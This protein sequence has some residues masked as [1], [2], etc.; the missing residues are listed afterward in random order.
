M[1][2][3]YAPH[4]APPTR[5]VL[6]RSAA[7]LGAGCA[8]SL[9]TQ[10]T[11]APAVSAAPVGARTMTIALGALPGDR[12]G[13]RT[14]RGLT[15]R[16]TK[17]YSLL[18]VSWDDPDARLTGTV[19][20]RTRCAGH[21]SDWQPLA[22]DTED[23]PDPAEAEGPHARGSTAPRWVGP[24]DGVEVRVTGNEP[25]PAGLRVD[26]VDPGTARLG[27]HPPTIPSDE[28][29]AS[30]PD[31]THRLARHEVAHRAPRPGIVTR[32]GWGADESLR[33]PGFTYT[34][35]VRVVFVHHTDTANDY[36]CDDSPKV[37]RAIYQYHV[38]TNGWNDI[39]YNFLVDRCGTIY[40]GR[41]GGVARPVLGAHTLG[42][43]ADTTGV[44]AL[45]SF[46]DEEPPQAQVDGV[47][48]I[49][50]WK[51]GLTG[52]DALGSAD[53]TSASDG[54]RYPLGSSHSFDTIAGHRDAFATEC[55]GDQLYDRLPAVRL[56]AGHLQGRR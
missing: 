6:T 2:N 18:G 8:L 42:F 10:A 27:A 36:S 34:G 13:G 47:T 11:A 30:G 51:L 45:G 26:L 1:S 9:L 15:A 39:G 22:A 52:Q 46:G 44:A 43:N 5:S 16:G 12:T 38:Q 56:L 19:Q 54:S 4:P 14:V 25:L 48:K 40:E 41:A 53:L 29:S 37:I 17:R 33:H 3:R 50:A 24:S 21:W 35:A 20:V 55:P 49:A 28:A 31:A 23:R 7:L 32:A